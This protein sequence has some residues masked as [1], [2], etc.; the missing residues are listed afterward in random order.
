MTEFLS[1]I[2][3]ER[4]LLPRSSD[5]RAWGGVMENARARKII[6][7]IRYDK[8]KRP[9]LHRTPKSVLIRNEKL[10]K[11]NLKGENEMQKL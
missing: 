10:L 9:E 7:W 6:D 11:T 3:A 8:C 2:K 1:E 4:E 5:G